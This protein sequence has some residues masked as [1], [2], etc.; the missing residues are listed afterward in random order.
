MPLHHD[1]GE[2]KL[3]EPCPI[4]FFFYSPLLF[5]VDV[6]DAL[7]LIFD[8]ISGFLLHLFSYGAVDWKNW[9]N[10]TVLQIYNAVE[11]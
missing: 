6:Y 2:E 3:R 9:K 8:W 4:H 5:L 10:A 11:R 7:Y 1:E